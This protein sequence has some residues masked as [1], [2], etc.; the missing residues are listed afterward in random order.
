[1]TPEQV[2]AIKA[3]VATASKRPAYTHGEAQK[4]K[5]S[6]DYTILYLSQRFGGNVRG[7]TREGGFWRLQTRP[8]SKSADNV[9]LLEHNLA[10]AFEHASFS[11]AGAPVH[12]AFEAQDSDVDRDNDG[13]FSRL[14]DWTFTL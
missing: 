1:M 3:V 4:S 5:P 13:Y 10:A 7:D 8:T 14:T 11:V 6:G 9:R 12:F 2:D